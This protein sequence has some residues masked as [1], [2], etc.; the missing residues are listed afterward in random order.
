MR[1]VRGASREGTPTAGGA[2]E[3]DAAH[4]QDE[5]DG[6]ARGGGGAL[7]ARKGDEDAEEGR[8]GADGAD[9]RGAR[10]GER[11]VL[12]QEVAGHAG[13][14]RRGKQAAVTRIRQA[15]GGAAAGVRAA[16]P[17]TNRRTRI[18]SGVRPAASSTLVA[19]KV[20]LQTRMVNRA[21]AC[22]FMRAPARVT[23]RRSLSG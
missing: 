3:Q 16:K 18:H 19:T 15:A 9:G 5:P 2:D 1:L 7:P 17:K 4:G 13:K 12:Q 22:A 6:E 11:H 14:A 8:G 10:E 20:V 23:N 21:S